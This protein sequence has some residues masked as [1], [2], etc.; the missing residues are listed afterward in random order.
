[1]IK[2]LL[3]KL[4]CKHD[5]RYERSLIETYKE[6]DFGGGGYNTWDETYD[7]YKCIKC[8]KTKKVQNGLR[9]F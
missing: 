9:N 5:Y 3:K 4:F 7:I 8:G 1:M 2:K 6:T